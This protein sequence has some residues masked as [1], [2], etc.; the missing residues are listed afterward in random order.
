MRV[1]PWWYSPLVSY[2]RVGAAIQNSREKSRE[3]DTEPE[4]VQTQNPGDGCRGQPGGGST[5][6][7]ASVSLLDA[8]TRLV[9]L[10]DNPDEAPVLRPMFTREIICRLL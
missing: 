9:Q 10:L 8:A 5:E 6:L 1:E 4:P 7:S 3:L 2:L